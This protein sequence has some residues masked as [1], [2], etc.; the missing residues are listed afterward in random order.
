MW[1]KTTIKYGYVGD[2]ATDDI[3]YYELIGTHGERGIDGDSIEYIYILTKTGQT[4]STPAKP[5]PIET[6]NT[7]GQWTDDP[8]DV[9]SEWKYQWIS[10]HIKTYDES[11]DSMI[12]TDY[13][14][15]TIWTRY[16]EDGDSAFKSTVF[17]RNNNTPRLPQGGSY[18]DPIPRETSEWSDA[19]PDGNQTLLW[20][21][22]RVFTKSG[23]PPHQSEWTTPIKMMDTASFDVEYSSVENPEPPI[24]H[25]NTNAQ[26]NNDATSDAIWM[27]TSNLTNGKWTDWKVS[28]VKGEDGRDGDTVFKST[29]FIRQ[30]NMPD[31]P[32]GGSFDD[33]V[34]S[35]W[36]DGV[37]SGNSIVWSS[38]RTFAR[39]G[40]S[41]LQTEWTKPVKMTDTATF[42]VEWSSVTSN[43]GTPTDNPSNWSNDSSEATIWM[44]TRTSSN[45]VWGDWQISKIKGENGKDG[46]G[47]DEVIEYYL[48]HPS[49]TGVTTSTPGWSQTIPT[50]DS[51]NKYLWNYERINYT[52]GNPMDTKPV[53]IGNY[54][55]DG[56][57]GKGIKSIT[58]KYARSSSSTT[59]PTDW[60]DTPPELTPTLRCLWNYEIVTYTDDSTT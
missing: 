7:P 17:T 41:S 47:I 32:Q 21:S 5:D 24:G 16:T 48:A 40:D 56:K 45:G 9:D 55:E 37:P 33:P 29:V 20:A 50:L 34:P 60:V 44:A 15:P 35:G 6:N 54:A 39:S 2:S 58:E 31:T 23:N 28:K 49:Q 25:P 51:T 36:S 53:I 59:T 52:S 30:N 46:K 1:K 11:T 3:T 57:A 43:P 10:Q 26:W 27:A 18:D 42:D 14:T 12:W 13:S 8:M 19:I 22:T 4:P 38:S